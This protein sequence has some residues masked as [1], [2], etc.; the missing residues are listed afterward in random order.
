MP[1]RDQKVGKC[2]T[3]MWWCGKQNRESEEVLQ[4]RMYLA[5]RNA[6]HPVSKKV[7]STPTDKTHCQRPPL[8]CLSAFWVPWLGVSMDHHHLL[9]C[10]LQARATI[11]NHFPCSDTIFYIY[12]L[13]PRGLPSGLNSI[14]PKIKYHYQKKRAW[15]KT[16]IKCKLI[17]ILFYL[18]ILYSYFSH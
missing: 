15:H 18:Y 14:R 11:S 4:L 7:S 16:F 17:Y 12:T 3:W 2:R 9:R 6:L 5:H 10:Q 1:D 8:G 13:Q